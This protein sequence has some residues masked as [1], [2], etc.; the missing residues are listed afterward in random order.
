MLTPSIVR[1][2]DPGDVAD[3]RQE[4]D[5]RKNGFPAARPLRSQPIASSTT[6][7]AA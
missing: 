7:S 3:R 4:V 6:S 5:S 2:G 1:R